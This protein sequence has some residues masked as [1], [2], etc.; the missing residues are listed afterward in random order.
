MP[1]GEGFPQVSVGEG[2]YRVWARAIW[3]GSDLVVLLGGGTAPHVGAVSVAFPHPSL[4]GGGRVSCTPSLLTLP[5]H[6]EYG[7]ALAGAEK[8]A[9][10]TGVS[11]VVIVGIHL[12]GASA[13]DVATLTRNAQETLDRLVDVLPRRS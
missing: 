12:E 13:S 2:S 10:A 5:T 7:L 9:R 11:V 8:L 1:E 6:K 4:A 3:M